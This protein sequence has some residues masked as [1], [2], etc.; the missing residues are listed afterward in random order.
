MRTEEMKSDLAKMTAALR[1]DEGT[2]GDIL[3]VDVRKTVD[4]LLQYGGPTVFF[5]LTFDTDGSLIEGEYHNSELSDPVDL[6]DCEL[7]ELEPY[8]EGLV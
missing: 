4:V 6:L 1:G 7:E 3:C 5:R 8:V 2:E